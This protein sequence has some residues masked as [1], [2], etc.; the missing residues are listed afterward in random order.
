VCVAE[1][2]V[3]ISKTV[4]KTERGELKKYFRIKLKFHIRVRYVFIRL[5]L[6]YSKLDVGDT[7]VQVNEFYDFESRQSESSCIRR[8]LFLFENK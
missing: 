5:S 1:I 7:F 4:T 2:K 6:P 8:T 3:V